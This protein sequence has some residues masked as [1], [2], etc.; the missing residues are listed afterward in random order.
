MYEKNKVF[1]VPGFPAET[2]TNLGNLVGLQ[3]ICQ[4]SQ[5]TT[6]SLLAREIS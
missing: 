4:E 2:N 6:S 5:S 1:G 3:Y